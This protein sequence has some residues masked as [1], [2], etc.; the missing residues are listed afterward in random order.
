M[1]EVQRVLDEAGRAALGVSDE[2]CGELARRIADAGGVFVAGAGRSGL[3]IR[4]FANRLM[5]LGLD[6]NIVGEAT[7]RHTRPGDLLIIGS[8]SGETSSLVELAHKAKASEV[9]IALVT[10][11]PDSAIGHMADSV[12][13]IPA[14]AKAEGGSAQPM[15]SA[16]EQA[17]LLTYDSIILM[18]MNL[19]GETDA[20]MFARHADLE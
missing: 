1:R 19:L 13:T 14:H 6:V 4:A 8:G 5:H 16:F 2:E 15:A 11:H 20:T 9:H 12:L 18:L 10:G 7:C 3:M 17:S